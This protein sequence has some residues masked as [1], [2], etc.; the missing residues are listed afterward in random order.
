MTYDDLISPNIVAPQEE[1]FM[2][3]KFLFIQSFT[4]S[5][6]LSAIATY[7]VISVPMPASF[8]E[9]II[10]FASLWT[11]FGLGFRFI[12]KPVMLYCIWKYTPKINVIV[13]SSSDGTIV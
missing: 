11:T 8:Q 13:P 10:S 1:P 4:L 9:L 12:G 6:Y 7:I 2:A 5:F 3:K